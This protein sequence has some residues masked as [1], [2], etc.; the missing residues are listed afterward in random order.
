M[1]L[2][3]GRGQVVGQQVLDESPFDAAIAARGI[4][5]SG[6]LGQLADGGVLEGLRRVNGPVER[7]AHTAGRRDRLV[8]RVVELGLQ[9]GRVAADTGAVVQRVGRPEGLL[10]EQGPRRD[11]IWRLAGARPEH[12]VAGEGLV[13]Q[14]RQ[15]I[16]GEVSIRL[17]QRAQVALGEQVED[18]PV[19]PLGQDLG[20]DAPWLLS[21]Q[22]RPEIV[23]APLLHNTAYGP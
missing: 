5:E 10:E 21:H 12:S 22:D 17:L 23:F 11:G 18:E 13:E 20:G 6:V 19:V 15:E 8:K 14:G 2:A 4:L 3:E 9:P 1:P 7:D 16:V